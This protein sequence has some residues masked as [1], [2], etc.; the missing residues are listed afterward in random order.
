MIKL[1]DRYYTDFYSFVLYATGIKEKIQREDRDP[2]DLLKASYGTKAKGKA[3]ELK[4]EYNKLRLDSWDAF[5]CWIDVQTG[6]VL[7]PEDMSKDIGLSPATIRKRLGI[8]GIPKYN[9]NED[10]PFGKRFIPDQI[11][12]ILKEKLEDWK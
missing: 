6:N 11:Y 12:G 7:T 4:E 10:N 5:A 9:G 8:L 3:K 1:T 2:M